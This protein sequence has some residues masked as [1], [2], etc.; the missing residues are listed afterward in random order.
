M[1]AALGR[2]RWHV[3]VLGGVFLL[4]LAA[5]LRTGGRLGSSAESTAS[6]PSAPR[7][8]RPADRTRAIRC[9]RACYAA[10][11]LTSSLR[12]TSRGSAH[13]ARAARGVHRS[14]W[15]S[16]RRPSTRRPRATSRP[17]APSPCNWSFTFTGDPATCVGISARGTGTTDQCLAACGT[18]S[19]GED[20]SFCSV[21]RAGHAAADMA[22]LTCSVLGL[23]RVLAHPPGNGGRRPEYFASIG[24][25][26]LR[27]GPGARWARTSPA[28]PAWRRAA[29]RP[30]ARCATSS[31]PTARRRRL[32]RAASR[33]VRD[34]MRHVRQTSALAR[35]FGEEPIAPIPP[36]P[37]PLRSL[38]AIA[39]ENALEGCVRETFSALECAW[40]AVRS[41]DPVVRATMAR[42]AR[43]EMRHLALSWEVHR[44]ALSRLDRAQREAIRTAQHERDRRAR[45]RGRGRPGRPRWCASWACPARSSRARSSAPSPPPAEGRPAP[46][47]RPRSCRRAH[48]ARGKRV[49][50]R[51]SPPA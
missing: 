8:A 17:R 15:R 24:V 30:S 39:R 22:T 18:N 14:W 45:A 31:S 37:R 40:Q 48:G 43:D 32:V 5:I 23:H 27:V 49:S 51:W 3:L 36:P 33:A 34:E 44:W 47:D 1:F 20:P 50:W 4:R 6:R 2:F 19:A 38:A 26:P 28:S 41:A 12:T 35:R 29:S 7:P 11:C 25:R 21:S 10:A 46:E 16:S 13:G 42:I 9:P